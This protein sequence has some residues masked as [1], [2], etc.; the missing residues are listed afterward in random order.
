[1]TKTLTPFLAAALILLALCGPSQAQPQTQLQDKP[2]TFQGEIQVREIGLVV[3]PPE[4]GPFRQQDLL[5]FEAGTPRQVLK[6]EPLRPENG[7]RPWNLVLYFDRTLAAPT[8][9]RGAALALARQAGRLTGLGTVEVAV[10]DPDPRLR[11]TATADAAGLSGA[12]GEIAEQ[13]RK[14]A[15]PK[16]A[17][18]RAA[19]PA[20]PDAATLRRQLDRLTTFLAGRSGSGARALFLVVDGF[21]PPPGEADLI[22]APDTGDPAPPGT[23]T[24]ALRE[25]SRLLAASGWVTFAVPFRDTGPTREQ[26]AQNDMERIRVQA[27]GSEHTN[28]APPVIVMRPSDRGPLRNPGIT[29]VFTEPESAPLMALV[30]PTAG[31]VLGVEPQLRPAVEGLARR[32]RVWYQAPDSPDGKLHP[33]EVRL[34]GAAAPLRCPRWVRTPVDSKRSGS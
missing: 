15:A 3:E 30:Q 32:W 21:V 26:R 29:D 33:V 1:M 5:V 25:T 31:T 7:T 19:P 4:S 14:S 9:I 8:T 18:R 17:G 10:A 34:P 22:S 11:L 16:P 24:A 6:A 12:L 13:A 23:A 28:S 27:G 20:S 2:Q